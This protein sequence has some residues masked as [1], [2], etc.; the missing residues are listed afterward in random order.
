MS[1]IS[2]IVLITLDSFVNCLRYLCVTQIS[3]SFPKGPQHCLT[4]KRKCIITVYHSNI[5]TVRQYRR[6][7]AMKP[8]SLT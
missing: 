2:E 5:L 6:M 7:E 1:L 3:V 8:S 4:P